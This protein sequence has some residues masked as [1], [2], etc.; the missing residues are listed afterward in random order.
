MEKQEEEQ[1]SA[2]V[3]TKR[4]KNKNSRK[5]RTGNCTFPQQY[6]PSKGLPTRRI[7]SGLGVE[8]K[9]GT[10]FKEVIKI[11][12]SIH[13]LS[14]SSK[15]LI[16]LKPFWSS[17]CQLRTEHIFMCTRVFPEQDWLPFQRWE[18]EAEKQARQ[19]RARFSAFPHSTLS[20]TV[21]PAY[22][23][24][25]PLHIS[26]YRW[27]QMVDCISELIYINLELKLFQR[28]E[29]GDSSPNPQNMNI[30]LAKI[31]QMH[32]IA[33]NVKVYK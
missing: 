22:N 33:C 14:K 4:N 7:H 30:S 11:Y 6:F 27:L 18:T 2:S 31:I 17:S 1:F 19:G 5:P 12:P 32:S 26:D 20:H 23:L 15:S 29:K 8:K 24:T 16:E 21:F 13:H 28:R 25:V 10:F 9:M 3:H